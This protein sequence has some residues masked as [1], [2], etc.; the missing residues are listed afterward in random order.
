MAGNCGKACRRGAGTFILPHATERG[1]AR[2]PAATCTVTRTLLRLQRD[3]LCAVATTPCMQNPSP[4][5]S[6]LCAVL[7]ATSTRPERWWKCGE[8]TNSCAF[9]RRAQQAGHPE[10]SCTTRSGAS[11]HIRTPSNTARYLRRGKQYR[12][13]ACAKA[14]YSAA[15]QHGIGD[16]DRCPDGARGLWSGCPAPVAG[17]V[18]T[19]KRASPMDE[20]RAAMA[21]ETFPTSPGRHIY[22]RHVLF[23]G[24]VP[25]TDAGSLPW[26]ETENVRPTPH[27]AARTVGFVGSV[28]SP[29]A[30]PPCQDA[31]PASSCH[32]CSGLA[33][34]GRRRHKLIAPMTSTRTMSP[35][36]CLVL[37][38][39]NEC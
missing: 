15:L 9:A 37:I 8:S 11:H 13:V 12:V 32:E 35:A 21:G 24:R 10:T 2:P 38:S 6:R 7:R 3:R 27:T 23:A 34:G 20:L 4:H 39:Q 18:R 16:R 30:P 1:S 14:E 36:S 26:G 22:L 31:L 17:D 29:Q 28:P 25:F 5:H 33:Q 19:G